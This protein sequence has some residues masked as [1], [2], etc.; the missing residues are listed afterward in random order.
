MESEKFYGKL[1]QKKTFLN[2]DV[3][4]KKRPQAFVLHFDYDDLQ[5]SLF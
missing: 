4:V 2:F 3:N 1:K 5:I